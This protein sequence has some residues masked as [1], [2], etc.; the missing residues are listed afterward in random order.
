MI[1][2]HF[3]R[4][5]WFA[6]LLPMA[7]LV[8][9]FLKQKPGMHSWSKACDPHLLNHLLQNKSQDKRVSS[10]IVLV[11]G[12]CF[13]V[14][15]LAGPTWSKNP[16]P[17]FKNAL[18]KVIIL[19]LS[20]TMLTNDIK[21]NRLKRAKYVLRDLFQLNH[22]DLY[23]LI[24]F[25]NEPF[26]VSPV[27]EDAKTIEALLPMLSPDIMPVQG[28]ELN[29]AIK[30]GA[31]LIHQSGYQQGDLLVLTGTVPSNEAVDEA[32]ALAKGGIHT[33][34]MPVL[35]TQDKNPLFERLASNGQGMLLAIND[36]DTAL[37]NWLSETQRRDQFQASAHNE[38]PIW[39]DQGRWF[40]I[41]AL[42]CLMPFFRRGWIQRL[43]T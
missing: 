13:L 29:D 11:L 43:A 35:K 34:I 21:P 19:D 24:A 14:V 36:N 28:H 26:T 38:I 16:V 3:L 1:E 18:P 17:T 10:I 27:T 7:F 5:Y 2:F 40:L 25:T 42:F 9:L 41:P 22:S 15:A 4:P 6:L 20:N 33:S 39:Q 12:F 8:F 37:K 30:A 32:K 31:K 23:G